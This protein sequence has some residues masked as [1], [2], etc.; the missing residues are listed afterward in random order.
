MMQ[1]PTHNIKR[2]QTGFTLMEVMVALVIFSISLL[3]LAGLQSQSLRF[4]NSA[5]QRSQAIYLAYDI[6]DRMRANKLVADNGSY[7]TAF[8]DVPSASS[9]VGTGA[10]CGQLAMASADLYEWKQA[11]N[12]AIPNGKGAITRTVINGRS[13]FQIQVQW[14]DPAATAVPGSDGKSTIDLR[15][16]L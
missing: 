5:Y 9:C 14:D 8:G 3:G 6:L 12:I 2:S 4:G 7:E 15:A 16:E 10:N 13:T 11:L 1:I